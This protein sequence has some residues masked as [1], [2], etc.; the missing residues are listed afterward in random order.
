MT[1]ADVVPPIGGPILQYGRPGTG[2]AAQYIFYKAVAIAIGGQHGFGPGLEMRVVRGQPAAVP[3]A[4][5][6]VMGGDEKR[7]K[8][9]RR[10]LGESAMPR[11]AIGVGPVD[12]SVQGLADHV[13]RVKR[14]EE[15]SVG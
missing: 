11:H 1:K 15:R 10:K 6:A 7:R 13:Q 14:S 12:D 8:R 2:V 3:A 9:I 4:L 5:N